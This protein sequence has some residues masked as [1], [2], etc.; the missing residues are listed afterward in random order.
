MGSLSAIL[1]KF[2]M[3]EFFVFEALRQSFTKNTLHELKQLYC[4]LHNFKNQ[5][6]DDA[7]WNNKITNSNRNMIL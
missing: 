5:G 7:D 3:I 1:H 2:F 4:V 6:I